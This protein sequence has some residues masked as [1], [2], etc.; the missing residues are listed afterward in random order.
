MQMLEQ[1][2]E[3]DFG[4][5]DLAPFAEFEALVEKLVILRSAGEE[6]SI[7]HMNTNEWHAY[8]SYIKHSHDL[9]LDY[10]EGELM[11]DLSLRYSQWNRDRAGT[12]RYS[13]P[14]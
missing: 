2:D 8:T 13:S 1:R 4:M 7:V 14:S 9:V 3:I 11:A 5:M 10:E 12:Q 6:R